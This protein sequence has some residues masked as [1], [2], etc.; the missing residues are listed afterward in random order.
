MI[1]CTT[2]LCFDLRNRGGALLGF[3]VLSSN[4]KI[5]V[6]LAASFT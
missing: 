6:I 4:A 1:T 2:A 5:F 3:P